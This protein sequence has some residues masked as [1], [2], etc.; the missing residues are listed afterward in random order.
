MF[1]FILLKFASKNNS[2]KAVKQIMGSKTNTIKALNELGRFLNQFSSESIS[3]N[4]TVL[5]N[6]LFFDGFQHQIKLSKEHNGWFSQTNLFFAI[7]NWS[8][9]LNTEE[10][11]LIAKFLANLLTGKLRKILKQDGP[12]DEGVYERELFKCELIDN[13]LYTAS[14][15]PKQSFILKVVGKGFGRHQI[16]LMMGALI[17]LG[18]EEIDMEYIKKSLKPESKY[19]MDYIAPASGLILHKIEYNK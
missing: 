5:Y 12:H 1:G 10:N 18:R 15:F 4:D 8:S 14:F 3:K 6:D 16:R 11:L 2:K 13:T 9:L 19:V 17:K 7:E